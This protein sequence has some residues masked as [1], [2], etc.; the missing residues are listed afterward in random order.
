MEIEKLNFR[1]AEEPINI[2]LATVAID[3]EEQIINIINKTPE[4]TGR[5]YI[6]EVAKILF[7]RFGAERESNYP[8]YLVCE[9]VAMAIAVIG[10]PNSK[11]MPF[12]E[13][14]VRED[15]RG[16][17]NDLEDQNRK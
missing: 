6:E 12:T 14:Y 16:A 4:M 2:G 5:E 7:I 9:G 3:V 11:F 17:I 15:I 10:L 1:R 8:E 13:V